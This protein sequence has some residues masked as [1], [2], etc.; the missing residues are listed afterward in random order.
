MSMDGIAG[1][2]EQQQNAVSTAH[3]ANYTHAA[4]T[5]TTAPGTNDGSGKYAA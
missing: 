3:D 5:A 1:D 4:A 2:D